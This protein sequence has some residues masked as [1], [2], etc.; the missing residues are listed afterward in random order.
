MNDIDVV[1]MQ[2]NTTQ[3]TGNN[4]GAEGARFLS[5]ALKTNTTLTTFDIGGEQEDK[6][7]R[8]CEWH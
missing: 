6:T 8:Q 1:Q 7:K 5:E 4:I 2:H 3:Q